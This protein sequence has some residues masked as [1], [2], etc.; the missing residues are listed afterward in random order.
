MNI[1]ALD[2]Q[3]ALSKVAKIRVFTIIININ[4]FYVSKQS[5]PSRKRRKRS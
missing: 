5:N 1:Y 2:E 4:T 3:T